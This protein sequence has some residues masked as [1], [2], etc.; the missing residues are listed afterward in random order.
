[1]PGPGEQE[2]EETGVKY[3]WFTKPEIA[4]K[5]VKMGEVWGSVREPLISGTWRLV[6]SL[7][8]G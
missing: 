6:F 2:A 4:R 5:E 7:A 8:R 1:M 3:C